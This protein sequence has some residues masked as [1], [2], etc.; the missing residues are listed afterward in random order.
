MSAVGYD[1]INIADQ[2]DTKRMS[3]DG[4]IASRN[5]VVARAVGEVI[6]KERRG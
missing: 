1:Y 6:I 3:A 5:R 4:R 2:T